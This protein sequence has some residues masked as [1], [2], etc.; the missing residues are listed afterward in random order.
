MI[1]SSVEFNN[2]EYNNT[3]IQLKHATAAEFASANP[4]LA[5]GEM[6][7]ETD[8]NKFKFGDSKSAYN[9]LPYA[10]N[11]G[12]VAGSFGYGLYSMSANQT[13]SFSV[14]SH[15]EWDIKNSGSLA[16]PTT[17]TGQ[18]KGIITL[19]A[20][21]TYKITTCLTANFLDSNGCLYYRVYDRT[22]SQYLGFAGLAL[23]ASSPQHASPTEDMLCIVTPETDIDIDIRFE[24]IAGTMTLV[25][26][27]TYGWLL[28][29]EYGGC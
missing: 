26:G 10:G 25:I 4:V 15:V 22:H 20:G 16:S 6:G 2:T 9:N 7:V 14:G 17:G 3:T 13:N 24:T 8:T 23:P 12:T 18:E 27:Y 21:K 28:I 1:K 19:K 29:E 5:K 11:G